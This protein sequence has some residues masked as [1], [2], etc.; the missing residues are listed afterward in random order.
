[1]IIDDKVTFHFGKIK[2]QNVTLLSW[3]ENIKTEIKKK[4]KL[5]WPASYGKQ[6]SKENSGKQSNN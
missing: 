5:K 4:K 1:L 2:I 6:F 3:L